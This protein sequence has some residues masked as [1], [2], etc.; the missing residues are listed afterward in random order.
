MS[1]HD[2]QAKRGKPTL[3]KKFLYR[4]SCFHE[5]EIRHARRCYYGYD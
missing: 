1:F 2:K 5:L 4:A 3:E